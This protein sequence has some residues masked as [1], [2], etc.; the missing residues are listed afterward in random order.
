MDTHLRY[1]LVGLVKKDLRHAFN[2]DG[3][4]NDGVLA[5]G[6]ARTVAATGTQ[7]TEDS[8]TGFTEQQFLQQVPSADLAQTQAP[9]VCRLQLKCD[10]TR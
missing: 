9:P 10:G 2:S 7:R 8:I 6:P 5:T 3:E 1:A 4:R